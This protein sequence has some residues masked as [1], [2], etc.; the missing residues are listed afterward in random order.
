MI[1]RIGL[2]PNFKKKDT[3][4]ISHEIINRLNKSGVDVY[5]TEDVA[6]KLES[7][8]TIISKDVFKNVELLLALGGDGTLLGVARQSATYGIPILGINFGHLGFLTEVET[9]E[10]EKALDMILKSNYTIEERMMLEASVKSGSLPVENYI[11]L[12]DVIVTK[13][14]F[15]RLVRLETYLD[16]EYVETYPADGLI[17]ATPTGS[18]AYSLSAGGPIITPDNKLILITPICPH[19]LHSRSIVIPDN[20]TVRVIVDADHK[21]I[22]MTVDG[23][24]GKRLKPGD[25]VT[26]KKASCVTRLIR[27]KHRTFYEVLRKKLTE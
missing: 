15:A 27:L 18:T 3:V 12:N 19:T 4:R 11:A 23:Q 24:Q 5:V 25:E 1:K 14:P 9:P 6:L 2:F 16:E 21:E 10:I 8:R 17:I 13:G 22:M 26:V 7:P 20:E